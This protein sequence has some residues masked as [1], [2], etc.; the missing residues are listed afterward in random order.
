MKSSLMCLA[1][2]FASLTPNGRSMVLVL[3]NLFTLYWKL[4]SYYGV[5]NS[6]QWQA[7]KM[8]CVY[9]QKRDYFIYLFITDWDS[10]ELRGWAPK[11]VQHDNNAIYRSYLPT[12]AVYVV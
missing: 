1:K 10:M 3:P 8:Y 5:Q 6:S 11:L 4:V 7:P 12:P 2:L 9:T